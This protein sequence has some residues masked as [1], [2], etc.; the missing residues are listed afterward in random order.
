MAVFR[1]P[2]DFY[3][4]I[5]VTG[6]ST[7]AGTVRINHYMNLNMPETCKAPELFD[8]L[9]GRSPIRDWDSGYSAYEA[10]TVGMA[11]PGE[12]WKIMR[13]GQGF[14]GC[15]VKLWNWLWDNQEQLRDSSDAQLNYIWMK[16]FEVPSEDPDW[17]PLQRMMNRG[18]FGYECLGFVANYLRYAG[19]LKYYEGTANGQWKKTFQIPVNDPKKIAAVNCVEWANGTHVAIIN[20]VTSTND[21]YGRAV[22]EICQS[23]SGG[24]RHDTGVTLEPLSDQSSDPDARLYKLDGDVPV[25]GKV[26][27]RKRRG[28]N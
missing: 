10:S 6:L 1:L 3:R 12:E 23:S 28:M 24:P 16:Y 13:K 19:I 18:Y 17:N 9:N 14:Y 20:A 2:A 26:W 8:P 7:N 22:V 5:A 21:G 11:Y 25:T 27:V 15:Y 4:Y